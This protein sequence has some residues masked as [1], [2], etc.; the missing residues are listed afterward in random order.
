MCSGNT[1]YANGQVDTRHTEL[2][3]AGSPPQKALKSSQERGTVAPEQEACSPRGVHRGRAT[4]QR[5]SPPQLR[6]GPSPRTH[7]LSEHPGSLA[8]GTEHPC[9]PQSRQAERG[10]P[11]ELDL[12][13][14]KGCSDLKS[15]SPE[16][17]QPLPYESSGI[18]GS[19]EP[20]S[21]F[22]LPPPC[23]AVA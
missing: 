12:V 10:G 1:C 16:A 3:Q 19:Q 18:R 23:W 22:L 9:Q 17:P 8:M 21:Q 11:C 7:P 2:N 13:Q 15:L 4:P 5:W 14:A 20:S 6:T